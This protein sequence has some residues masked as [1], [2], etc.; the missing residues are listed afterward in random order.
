MTTLSVSVKP[1]S[2]SAKMSLLLTLI[3][4]T[5]LLTACG[6]EKFGARVDPTA[7][8]VAIQDIFLQPQLLNQKV[9][10]QG[11][12]FTQCA[13]NG[14]WLV[15][16]DETAQIYVDLSTHNFKLPPMPGRQ[17]Q[18]TGIVATR[19]NNILLIAQGVE[20]I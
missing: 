7:P 10:V 19:Q 8:Q 18:A 14:C 3:F 17:I 5:L 2:V 9:T 6:K 12:V 15:L 13:S 1:R 11:K 16:K 20:T 4:V